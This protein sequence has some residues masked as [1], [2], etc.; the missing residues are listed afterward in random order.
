MHV[1]TGFIKKSDVAIFY[2]F[3]KKIRCFG[4]NIAMKC[5]TELGSTLFSVTMALMLLI[6]S[7]NSVSG[8]EK[9]MVFTLLISQIIVH[10]VKR[11]INRP[12][13]YKTLTDAVAIKPPRCEYSFPS[14]HTCAAF[15]IAM[16]LAHNLPELAGILLLTAF[17]VGLSRI[18]LGFHYPTDVAAGFFIALITF[19]TV[20][21]FI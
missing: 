15:S 3:N 6:Y 16:V 7:W 5:I 9:Q 18:Y 11:M 2:L 8:I 12:R 21:I 1:L 20:L 14:G 17:L 10:A 4:M 13:P 19:S